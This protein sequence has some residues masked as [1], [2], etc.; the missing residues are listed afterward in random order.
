MP[1]IS[2]IISTAT[3]VG[4]AADRGGRVQGRGQ[5]EHAGAVGVVYDAGDVGGQVHHVGQVQ[6]ERHL[7]HVHRGA[8]RRERLG[9]R[10]DGVLVL[11]E[12]LGG[13]GQLPGERQVVLVVAGTPDR[14]GQ[15]PGGD[16]AAF[17]AYEHLRGGAEEPVDVEGPAHLVVLGQPAQRPPH[18]DV[19]VGGGDEVASEHDL[20]QLAGADPRHCVGDDRLP[21]GAAHRAVGEG[22]VARSGGP[23]P[24]R[25]APGSGLSSSTPMTVTQER[26]PRVPTTTRGTMSTL[27]PGSSAKPKLPTQIRPVPGTRDLVAHHGRVRDRAPPV[28]GVGEPVRALGLAA[29]GHAP[30]DDALAAAQP[31]R[32]LSGGSRSRRSRGR[33][34]TT[35]PRRSG[36]RA[37]RGHIGRRGRAAH[38]GSLR[39]AA[40]APVSGP[41]GYEGYSA[42]RLR[43]DL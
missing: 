3:L 41:S 11:L 24:A 26:S 22:D 23:R 7:G 9:D 31:G 4:G 17:A 42:H 1:S 38:A 12:V 6:H 8:V 14:A 33:P 21:G 18:V 20:L 2:A 19:G 16:Q 32:R 29:G 30:G 27:S 39:W 43:K 13:P 37:G 5:L 15:H 28:D 36:R 34:A 40:V 10:A 25:P 35:S